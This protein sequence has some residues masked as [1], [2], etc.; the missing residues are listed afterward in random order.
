MDCKAAQ[1]LLAHHVVG[2]LAPE[3]D[4]C[5]DLKAHLELCRPCADEYES[6]K[7]V[8]A[9]IYD[10]KAELV[11]AFESLE[12]N[13]TATRQDMERSWKRIQ[14]GLD[15]LKAEQTRGQKA[16]LRRILWRVS[17]VAACV[18]IS[19]SLWLT[20]S[21][22]EV[23]KTAIS[24]ESATAPASIRIELLSENSRSIIPAG[25]EVRTAAS[26]LKTL[27]VDGTHRLVMNSHTILTIKPFIQDSR[28][29]CA[30]DLKLG[31][32]LGHVKHTSS[33]FVVGTAHGQAV[34]TGTIFDIKT[35]K[36][37]TSLVVSDG[38]VQFRG[39]N[40]AVK[41]TAGHISRIEARSAPT[42]PEPCDPA[43]WTVWALSGD[44]EST[45]SNIQVAWAGYDLS[46]LWM[47]SLSAPADLGAIDYEEWVEERRDWFKKE[48]PWIFE[49]KEA[50][51]AEGVEVDYPKLLV[52]AG[53]IW[54]F[55]HPQAPSGLIPVLD[56]NSLCE[57]AAA[58]GFS[59]QWLLKSVPAARSAILNP[60]MAKGR[61][62]GL[63][64]LE[65]WKGYFER[66]K[67]LSAEAN[68]GMYLCSIRA[69]V[70][71][72]DTRT[73]AWLC[74]R[75]NTLACEAEEKQEL[76]SVLQR[77]IEASR[78]S[79]QQ[80]VQ[81]MIPVERRCSMRYSLLERLIEDIGIMTSCEITIREYDIDGQ[82]RRQ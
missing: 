81:L 71:L 40:G 27:L 46:D 9:F 61:F 35:T 7:S 64:A 18:V 75:N 65:Q 73:L 32:I 72:A 11:E 57:V 34:I 62:S 39:T 60:V 50:L 79:L 59:R 37:A 41:V 48:F 20:F 45:V 82:Y 38:E 14:A 36:G 63:K 23:R 31:E 3:S 16:R 4:P 43:K 56:P 80:A 42:K 28:S 21:D 44:V 53:D 77:Q 47:T 8:V 78:D 2:A 74:T 13:R 24:Q 49:L 52:A 68:V 5:L 51:A 54:Q 15:K 1:V 33:P 55:V 29:G 76:L 17:A 10:H 30:V 69:S 67:K 22:S 19:I 25:S 12:K 70:Y 58:Y 66:A 26:E 6:S